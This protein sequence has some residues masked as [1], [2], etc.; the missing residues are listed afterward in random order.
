MGDQ[1]GS[2]DTFTLEEIAAVFEV[3]PEELR[4]Y[5][6]DYQ[7]AKVEA[8]RQRQAFVTRLRELMPRG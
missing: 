1:G 8:E 5:A 6:E 4:E 7:R 2:V 3:D